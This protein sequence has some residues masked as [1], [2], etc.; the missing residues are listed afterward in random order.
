MRPILVPLTFHIASLKRYTPTFS[1][2]PQQLTWCQPF[3]VQVLPKSGNSDSCTQK[4][5]FE[6]FFGTKSIFLA[7]QSTFAY[8]CHIYIL[9]AFFPVVNLANLGTLY[10]HPV[11]HPI[12]CNVLGINWQYQLK[13]CP[14][15]E[16]HTRDQPHYHPPLQGHLRLRVWRAKLL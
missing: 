16:I 4:A 9:K 14:I 6:V 15:Q 11:I 5:V 1:G 12:F 8:S 10:V 2:P 13:P 7:K 3:C